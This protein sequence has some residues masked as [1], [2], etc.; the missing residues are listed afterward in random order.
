MLDDRSSGGTFV[1]GDEVTVAKLHDGDIVRVGRVVFRYTEIAAA[2]K[3]KRAP[4]RI[5]LG[6]RRARGAG[7]APAR[8]DL[9]RAPPPPSRLIAAGRAPPPSRLIAAGRHRPLVA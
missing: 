3:R 2:L 1:N 9:G 5:P 7:A 4:R 8:S 6:V